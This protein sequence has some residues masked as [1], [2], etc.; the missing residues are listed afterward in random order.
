MNIKQTYRLFL[1]FLLSCSFTVGA[2]N[3]P[4]KSIGN[5]E[6]YCYKVQA[7][8]TIFGIAKKFNITQEDLKKYNPAIMDGLKKDYVLLIPVLLVDNANKEVASYETFTHT[9]VKGETLYGIAKTYNISQ[10][11]IVALNPEA[12]GGVKAGQVLV[13][14]QPASSAKDEQRAEFIYHTIAKGETLYSL[15]KR[16][17]TTIEKILSLN[18]GVSP[19]NF[20]IN[21]VLKIEPNTLTE[22]AEVSTVTMTPYVAKSGDSFKSISKK[23]GIDVDELKAANPNISKVKAGQTV[24]IPILVHDSIMVAVNDDNE[25]ELKENHFD[26]V[27]EIFDAI[28]EVKENTAVN[29]ALLLPYMLN[30]TIV[31]KQAAQYT[32]FYKG[33]LL[34]VDEV[35]KN[36]DNKINIFTY[37]TQN[38]L[39][40]L[41]MILE[42]PEMKDMDVI[43]AAN[44]NEQLNVLSQYANE[45]KIY[46]INTFSVKS[47]QYETS[48]YAIQVNIPQSFMLADV[49]DW[50]DD[51]FE[52]CDVIM[53]HKSGSTKKDLTNELKAHIAQLGDSIHEVEYKSILKPDMISEKMNP[54]KRYVI[55]PTSGAK[56]VMSQLV[57]SVK[58][59]KTERTDVSVSVLGCPEWVVYMEDWR[60]DFHAIDTYFYSRFFANPDVKKINEFKREYS[61]WYGEKLLNAAPCFGFLGYDTGMFFLKNLCERGND[62]STLNESYEGLQSAFEFER[63]NNWSGFVNKSLYFIHLTPFN[64]IESTVR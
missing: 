12:H 7:K 55:I 57:L 34:A 30:D 41:N 39:Q 8:E 64:T 20:K 26:R 62:F 43:F 21:T 16:Y 58:K 28:H 14:P 24:Q 51:V 6:F 5:T 47:E 11:D 9:V 27:K 53:V 52:G 3:L 38:N 45:N 49:F 17:N 54:G 61:R 48:P 35:R 50:Y 33:F 22:L 25:S 59:T 42:K 18:P 36:Y 56:D 1:V 29:V 10:A 23:T 15:S 32:E 2:W 31:S 63:V 40:G 4:K 44:G 60:D 13:I 19:T 37:D 46:L